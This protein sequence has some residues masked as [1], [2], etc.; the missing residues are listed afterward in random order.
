M[1]LSRKC[2]DF[3]SSFCIKS[4]KKLRVVVATGSFMLPLSAQAFNASDIFPA[5][6][7]S[8]TG[9]QGSQNNPGSPDYS[10]GFGFDI[11]SSKYSANALGLSAQSNLPWVNPYTVTLWEYDNSSG[12]TVFNKLAERY[13]SPNDPNLVPYQDNNVGRIDSYWLPLDV[14]VPLRD[15]STAVDPNKYY[16]YVIAASG[17]FN[18]PNGNFIEQDG[19]IKFNFPFI[20]DVNLYSTADSF[21]YPFPFFVA[22]NSQGIPILAYWNPNVSAVPGPLPVVVPLL[23]LGWARRLRRRIQED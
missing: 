20:Y 10:F 23:S 7:K 14:E 19:M 4:Q 22:E 18:Q 16:G 21:G 12:S 6:I 15:T 2:S 9:V 13:F 8:T 5:F 3:V 1:F 11:V 17:S